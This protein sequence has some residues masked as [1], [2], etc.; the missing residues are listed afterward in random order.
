MNR[1]SLTTNQI[2]KEIE[3]ICDYDIKDLPDSTVYLDENDSYSYR[4]PDI[5]KVRDNA[6]RVLV[7]LKYN[8]YTLIPF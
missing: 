3:D 4:M 2:I 8:G 7:D 1:I 6:I 5:W